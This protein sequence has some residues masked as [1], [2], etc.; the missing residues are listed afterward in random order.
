[1]LLTLGVAAHVDAG[2]TTLCEQL[3]LRGGV[4]RRGGR[5]DHGDAFMDGHA[6]ERARGITIFC[7]QATAQMRRESGETVHVTLMDTPGHVDFSGE[8]E[9]ALSVL[10]MALLVVSCTEGV[11]SHTVTLMRLLQKKKIPTLIFLNK[12]DREGADAQRVT[13]QMQ[14]LLSPDCVL[15]DQD[16]ETLREELAM[17]DD[18][19]MEQHLMEEAA[20]KDYLRGARRAVMACQLIPV[21]SGSALYDQGVDELMRAIA[22]LGDTNY[23]EKANGPFSG[24]VYRVAHRDGMRYCYVK[25]LTGCLRAKDEI[26]TLAGAQKI[27]AVF[28]AQGAKLTVAPELRAGQTAAVTGLAC[29]PGERIG[30]GFALENQELVPLMSVDVQ[31]EKGLDQT[32]LLAHLRELE[33]EDPLLCVR[34]ENGRVSV[35][36]MG[37]V[38]IEVLLS[39]LENRFGDKVSF[40][41]PKVMYKETIAEPAIG[42]GHYEPL[43]HYAEAWLRLV[44]TEEGTGIAFADKTP[45]N[46]LDMNWRRL[47]SSHVHERQH[48]G[49]LTGSPITDIRVELIAGRSHLKHTEGGD[50]REA[51][52]RA[53]RNALMQAKSVLL[54]P[55]VRFELAFHQEMLSR[56]TGELIRLGAELDAP[57]YDE[58]EVTLCGTC[59]A[60]A[61]WDYPQKFAAT[62]RGHGRIS[63]RFEKYAPCRNQDAVVQEI[64]YSA[65]ED[66]KN[67]PGSVF[68]SHGAGFYVAWDEVRSW[69][70]CEVE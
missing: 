1:M 48:P 65:L 6:L 61:F 66:V 36:I 20:R 32:K 69:A 35:G 5:V 30:E 22:E 42:I 4:L 31:G 24:R 44:P 37:A 18:V 12:M 10:D 16:A 55:V 50:F 19:L 21:L 43:R 49:V 64:G 45:A 58:D 28:S 40:L 62:T 46:M 3:L 51:T 47:I 39:V 53:I 25:A 8:M 54:E 11:Q 9:R 7:E 67:P 56:V 29:R 27:N 38:Q 59:T 23:E 70:H 41:P 14:R 52:Y 26:T 57:E 68:C 33:E 2:K 63:S 15:M 13:A 60:A 34:A 17:R